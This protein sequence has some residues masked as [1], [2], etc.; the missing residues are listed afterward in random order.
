[1]ESICQSNGGCFELYLI[2][3]RTLLLVLS[4]VA[5][6][7]VTMRHH[8]HSYLLHRILFYLCN[9]TITVS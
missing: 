4:V 8:Y 7:G 2:G 5:V 9:S 6:I 3:A 1:M